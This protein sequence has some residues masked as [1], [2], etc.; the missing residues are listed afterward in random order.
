MTETEKAYIAGII[1]GEGSIMLTRFHS[2]QY[3][4]PCISIASTDKELLYWMETVTNMGKIISKKN[5]NKEKHK[6]SFTYRVSYNDALILLK[7]IEPYLIINRKKLRAKL[8]LEKYKQ[9]TPRNGKYNDE[10]KRRKEEFYEEFMA[11]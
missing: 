8:I 5:Y 4:S 11:L 1:D 9:V 7:E 10:S 6:D 2:N 3:H